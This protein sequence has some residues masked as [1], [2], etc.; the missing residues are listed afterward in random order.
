MPLGVKHPMLIN[1]AIVAN[2]QGRGIDETNAATGAKAVFK[3]DAQGYPH[4]GHPLNKARVADQFGKLRSP[5][6][7]DLLLVEMLE[8]SVGCAVEAHQDCHDFAQTHRLPAIALLDS[9]TEERA[10][11]LRFKAA[12]EVIN[13]AKQLF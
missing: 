5:I 7:T 6:A 11:P 1:S 9:I 3:I 2:L 12:A 10:S 4:I 8:I 13:M